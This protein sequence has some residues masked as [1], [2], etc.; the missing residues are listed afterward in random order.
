MAQ[1]SPVAATLGIAPFGVDLQG[2]GAA[3]DQAVADPAAEGAAVAQHVD[4]LD[5]AGLAR[6]V[7]AHDQAQAGIRPQ[8]H[9][10]Q[11]AQVAN[12]EQVKLQGRCPGGK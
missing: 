8:L 10:G 11:A 1:P 9:L 4:R 7:G 2:A 5:Q 12:A 6:A 3:A